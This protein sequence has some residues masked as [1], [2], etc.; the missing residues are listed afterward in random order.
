[1]V[2]KQQNVRLPEDL[3]ARIDDWR[4]EQPEIPGRNE[5]I[6]QLLDAGLSRHESG[7][8]KRPTSTG[9]LSRGHP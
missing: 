1:M 4:R 3:L 8:R 9:R 5:A 2:K 7:R 6:R